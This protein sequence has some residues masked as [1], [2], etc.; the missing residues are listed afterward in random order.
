M[1]AADTMV[2]SCSGERL[3]KSI[4]VHILLNK[5]PSLVFGGNRNPPESSGI[6]RNPEE[7]ELLPTGIPGEKFL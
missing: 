4:L 2:K 7:Q 6:L 5:E 1:G 3:K